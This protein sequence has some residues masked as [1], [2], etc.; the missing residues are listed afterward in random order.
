MPF[1]YNKSLVT[2]YVTTTTEITI[3][4]SINIFA[5]FLKIN[6]VQLNLGKSKFAGFE[7][8][9]RDNLSLNVEIASVIKAVKHKR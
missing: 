8:S 9:V 4:T 1:V 3:Y 7:N 5:I 6:K 2:R